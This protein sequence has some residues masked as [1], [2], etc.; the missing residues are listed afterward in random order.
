MRAMRMQ[1]ENAFQLKNRSSHH[2]TQLEDP[3]SPGRIPPLDQSYLGPVD[4]EFNPYTEAYGTEGNLRYSDT[5]NA[6]RPSPPVEVGYGGGA[7]SHQEIAAEEKERLR[8]HEEAKEN[9]KF[10]VTDEHSVMP[11]R[12][13]IE[14]RPLS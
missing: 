3:I 2:Y 4:V 1:T 11:E 13:E 6:G 5:I 8:R 9:G 7:W 10:E 12:P 14:S